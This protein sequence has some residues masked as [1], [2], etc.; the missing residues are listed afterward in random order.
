MREDP[1]TSRRPRDGHLRSPVRQQVGRG[2]PA[3]PAPMTTTRSPGSS[4][5]TGRGAVTLRHPGCVR[6]RPSSDL[7]HGI[8]FAEPATHDIPGPH[9]VAKTARKGS[10][11]A[12][13][14]QCDTTPSD[15]GDDA[16]RDDRR[17]PY[18]VL[19]PVNHSA[20]PAGSSGT[21]W[22]SSQ[23]NAAPAERTEARSTRARLTHSAWP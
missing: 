15:S 2:K 20:R 3:G 12:K 16:R 6:R 21:G 23:M 19:F 7:R 22:L 1:P 18:A 10:E 4:G 14:A 17:Q 9:A 13:L 8:A 11:R 5:A